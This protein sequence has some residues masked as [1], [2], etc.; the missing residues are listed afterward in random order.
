MLTNW[1]YIFLCQK[2]KKIGKCKNFKYF[3]RNDSKMQSYVSQVN[4]LEIL[5]NANLMH[6][7][8]VNVSFK[9]Q[10]REI[11]AFVDLVTLS[12]HA[13]ET[14]EASMWKY[15]LWAYLAFLVIG[16]VA[17]IFI[18]IFWQN[19][20]IFCKLWTPKTLIRFLNKIKISCASSRLG[21]RRNMKDKPS[22]P[23][24]DIHR[25]YCQG[26]VR[27][28]NYAN[29]SFIHCSGITATFRLTC[30]VRYTHF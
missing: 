1:I 8:L 30:M 28:K 2:R 23:E 6:F 12:L 5:A 4:V 29:L 15:L 25:K 13:L 27:L 17:K 21:P 24:P 14:E 9:G 19:L 18:Q 16:R 22:K 20:D 10:C 7:S 3:F 11:L 26:N